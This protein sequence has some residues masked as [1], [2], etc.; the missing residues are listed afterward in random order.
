MD[1][2]L[3]YTPLL[4]HII[5]HHNQQHDS[6]YHYIHRY[7]NKQ[8]RLNRQQQL[9]QSLRSPKLQQPSNRLRTKE[10]KLGI[11]ISRRPDCTGVDPRRRNEPSPAAVPLL[12]LAKSKRLQRGRPSLCPVARCCKHPSDAI[13]VV[14]DCLASIRSVILTRRRSDTASATFTNELLSGN[15][16]LPE[17]VAE[18]PTCTSRL[19]PWLLERTAGKVRVVRKGACLSTVWCFTYSY[20][21][22]IHLTVEGLCLDKCRLSLI[23]L[24]SI[25]E[26][27]EV[28]TCSCARG[29]K[30]CASMRNIENCW[31]ERLDFNESE[32]ERKRVDFVQQ[33][34]D[35]KHRLGE[36]QQKHVQA[37]ATHLQFVEEPPYN[38]QVSCVERHR[39][40]R[41]NGLCQQ[42][43][44]QYGH[45]CRS[46]IEKTSEPC[47]AQC[48]ASARVLYSV[49]D[50]GY[51]ACICDAQTNDPEGE[52]WCRR[53]KRLIAVKCFGFKRA[54]TSG[55]ALPVAL[56]PILASIVPVGFVA[57]VTMVIAPYR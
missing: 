6:N 20:I 12:L 52:Y 15:R 33:R 36:Y 31:P 41:E 23:S 5:P 54:F 25:I 40:C 39:L 55:V 50:G 34:L 46:T 22:Y 28:I 32:F 19:Y 43:Y 8:L 53:Q 10:V 14:D 30:E 37:A 9:Q 16:H 26:G 49:S 11:I 51:F 24:S 35:Y 47:S 17:E 57:L 13:G 38:P 1:K 21:F 48:A 2:R 18:L 42:A 45:A 44:V 3:D 7:P 56:S 27:Y 29:D 4:R